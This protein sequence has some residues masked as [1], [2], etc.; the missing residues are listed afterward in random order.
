M[1]RSVAGFGL[2]VAGVGTWTNIL[3]MGNLLGMFG[4]RA[5]SVALV[6]GLGLGVLLALSGC[7]TSSEPN[8]ALAPSVDVDRFMGTWYVHGYVPTF[9][10]GKGFGAT[11]TYEMRD[12]GKI[13]T[14]YRYRKEDAEGKEKVLRPV[15]WVHDSESGAEWRMRFFG[16][17]T[18]P[19][20]ILY[21]SED[22][23]YTVVGQPGKKL[24]WIMSRSPRIDE[25]IYERLLSE[26]VRRDYDL[27]RLERMRHNN[28]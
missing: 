22:Y 15:G 17:F 6:V 26:L 19:Y 27:G 4:K 3:A 24:C 14:T 28:D 20:Y 8:Q 11:E 7:E 16:V 18:A 13:Q 12:D 21:V 2:R 5:C 25:T 1:V 10:D 9:I 23:E